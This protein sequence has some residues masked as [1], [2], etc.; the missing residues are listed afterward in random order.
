MIKNYLSI[1]TV[2]LLGLTGSAQQ[3]D[4]SIE[5]PVPVCAPGSCTELKANYTDVKETSSYIVNS[6]PYQNLYSYT[7]GTT[8]SAFQDDIWTSLINLPFNFCFYGNS[9][10]KLL[11]GS[12]GV[13]TFDIVNNIPGSICPYQ[14][15]TLIPNPAFPI[16]NAIY[17]VYQDTDITVTSAGGVPINPAIQ[18]VNYYLAGVAPNRTFVVNFNELPL[19]GPGNG[20]NLQTSQIVLYET[21]NVVDIFIKKRTNPAPLS[22]YINGNAVVGIQNQAGTTAAVPPGRNTGQWTTTNEAWRFQPAGNSLLTLSWSKDGIFFGNENPITVCPTQ[23]EIYIATVNYPR[24]DGTIATA[25]TATAVI[26]QSPLPVTDPLDIAI[27]TGS[28]PSFDLTTNTAVVLGA[29]NPDIFEVVY[30]TTY[31]DALNYAASIDSPQNYAGFDG[32]VIYVGIT[33]LT[34]G[35]PCPTI[36]N[37]TLTVNTPLV[38]PSGDTEQNFIEGETLADIELTGSTVDW[39]A[40]AEGGAPLPITTVLV[41]GT[42]YYAELSDTDNA[43]SGLG[44]SALVQRFAVTVSVAL[45]TEDW[46]SFR[47]KAVPNPVKD[48]LNISS[49]ANI[50]AVAVYNLL[51]QQVIHQTVNNT[52]A[53]ISMAGL[54]NGT[55]LMKVSGNN[56]VKTMKVIKQ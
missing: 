2:C 24:C 36:K 22:Q 7:G 14:F 5:T 30:Y 35:A 15:S 39:Y 1:L 46:T 19:F 49:T 43:C 48:I 6:I 32:Q 11:V 53:Q 21:T 12:N 17:G 27:C 45:A 37:F 16:R 18:N 31:Q 9:Y 47:F 56:F 50:T 29:L 44:R 28:A 40:A 8:I 10:D 55:Y 38:A 3:L 13:V 52:E 42:T 20:E 26:V 23:S 33:D 41:D 25:S 34:S 4:I 51:G 54:A